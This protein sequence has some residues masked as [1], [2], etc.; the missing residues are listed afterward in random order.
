MMAISRKLCCSLLMLYVAHISKTKIIDAIIFLLVSNIE[1]IDDENF[2]FCSSSVQGLKSKYLYCPFAQCHDL[3]NWL[4]YDRQIEHFCWHTIQ[5][6]NVWQLKPGLNAEVPKFVGWYRL[7][8]NGGSA[9][10]EMW[11]TQL[12]IGQP[13][14]NPV[15]S[16][17]FRWK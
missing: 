10:G 13:C 12:F 11:I 1:Y 4:T 15:K 16:S 5:A 6:V 9:N 7:E 2:S 8:R 17:T 3:W 14:V